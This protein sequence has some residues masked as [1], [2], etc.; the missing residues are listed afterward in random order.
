MMGV[1]PPEQGIKHELSVGELLSKT[2]EVYQKD[3]SKYFILFAIVGV[4]TGL[5]NVAVRS[6]FV[7]PTLPMNPTPQQFSEFFSAVLGALLVVAA[8]TLVVSIILFPIAQGGAMKMASER[9]DKGQASLGSSISFALSKLLQLWA[10]GIIVG[11]IVI[12]GLIALIV[13][14]IILGIMF[15]L[16]FPVLLIENKGVGGSIGRS[17]ELV[18]H[19]WGKTFVTF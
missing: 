3:F 5:L 11:F 17:R 19:R 18:S 12:V 10:L 7:F 14:G 6:L 9:I 4:V 1:P 16:S 8:T 13:P 2:F 15:C